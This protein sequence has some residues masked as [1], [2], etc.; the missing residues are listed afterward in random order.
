[1]VSK[2]ISWKQP[3]ERLNEEYEMTEKK[4]QALDNLLNDGRISQS[5]YDLFNKK[6]DE[7]IAEIER[8]QKV[9]LEKMNSK[10][11]ELEQHIK[12]LEMLLAN[13]EIGHVTGEIEEEVY[14]RE[15][16]L[17]STGLEVARQELD[18]VKEAVNELSS[19]MPIQTTEIVAPQE[20]ETT[21]D[22]EIP[23]PETEE[24][25]ETP[26][27][28]EIEQTP[29]E[30]VEQTLPEPPVESAEGGD[31]GT[32]QTPQEPEETE[33]ESWEDTEETEETA[34]STE[35]ET[36]SMEEETEETL[37]SMEEG[38]G[39]TWQDPE[40]TQETAENLEEDPQSTETVVEVE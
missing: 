30:A 37:G 9:L 3:F 27:V 24:V 19:S 11:G 5:T 26:Q 10:A 36:Q 4:K 16:D 40:D 25:G 23:E 17:L 1:M 33:Q 38:T 32:F 34:E 31:A 22:V 35:E 39:E 18:A 13:F 14:Q 29:E 21:E 28:V 2:L 12:T 15:V 7:A 8:K 20:T 6:I